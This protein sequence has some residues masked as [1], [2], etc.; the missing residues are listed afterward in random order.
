MISHGDI[1]KEDLERVERLQELEAWFYEHGSSIHPYYMGKGLTSMSHDYFQMDFEEEGDR[2]LKLAEK[3]SPGYF[4]G[5]IYQQAEK[6]KDFAQLVMNM[7][8]T[9]GFDTMKKLGFL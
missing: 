6:D 2:L 8:K 7:R 9:L 3:Y 1:P 4:K 5:P